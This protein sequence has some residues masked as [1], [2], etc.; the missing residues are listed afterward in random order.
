MKE[1]EEKEQAGQMTDRKMMKT[2]HIEE[3]RRGKSAAKAKTDRE[4]R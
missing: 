3:R 1:K 2:V 4:Q